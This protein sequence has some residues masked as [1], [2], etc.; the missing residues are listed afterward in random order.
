[1]PSKDDTRNQ[2]L[3]KKLKEGDI[4]AFD[5]LFYAFEPALYAYAM[6]LTHSAEDAKEVVQEVFLKVWEK[7]E[8][9]DPQYNFDSFLYTIAKN[10]VYNK[11][12]HRAYGF[13]YKE[14]VALYG[15]QTENVTENMVHFNEMDVL[16]QSVCRQLPPVRKE[17][18]M[19]SRIEGLSHSE[20]AEKLNTSTSNVKNHIHKALLFLKEQI[21][22]HEIVPVILFFPIYFLF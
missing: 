2:Q 21:R 11:A 6:K 13:A 19:L 1:M 10:L 8:Q 3:A 4:A 9:I 17:V 22:I 12:K 7:R 15:S 20:I 16:I 5:A 18:F 14:H